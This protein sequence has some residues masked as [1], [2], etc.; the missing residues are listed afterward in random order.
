MRYGIEK[1]LATRYTYISYS[2][3]HP[4]NHPK[5]MSNKYVLKHTTYIGPYPTKQIDLPPRPLYYT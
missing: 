2:A 5:H 4:S 1:I 3:M